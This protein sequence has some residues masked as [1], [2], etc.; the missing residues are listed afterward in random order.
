MTNIK[1]YGSCIFFIKRYNVYDQLI[2]YD[3]FNNKR[4]ILFQA[5]AIYEFCIHCSNLVIVFENDGFL[6][7]F[8]NNKKIETSIELCQQ[9]ISFGE[10]LYMITEES[11]IDTNGFIHIDISNTWVLFS[12]NGK[13]VMRWHNGYTVIFDIDGNYNS[14]L[15]FDY[16]TQIGVMT[17]QH[18]Y[19]ISCE[20]WIYSDF[21]ISYV[22]V[23]QEYVFNLNTKQTCMIDAN[24]KNDKYVV[25]NYLVICF[26]PENETYIIIYDV[27]TLKQLA[28]ISNDLK[29]FCANNFLNI[30]ITEDFRYFKITDQYSLIEIRFGYNYVV[31]YHYI[32]N[33]IKVM[34][35]IVLIVINL[36]SEILNV[37]LYVA[38]FNVFNP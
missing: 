15:D 7:L 22:F 25:G 33:K 29:F 23:Q 11:I 28:R 18:P 5:Q 9:L 35:D 24:L 12:N 1:E 26:R 32:S 36:P 13:R 14:I 38:L 16:R 3:I 20:Q 8:W 19:R 37:E 30:L 31:E 34:M 27:E 6:F 4:Y 2:K 10:K 21:L 17:L